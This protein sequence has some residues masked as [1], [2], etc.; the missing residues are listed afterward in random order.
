[1]MQKNLQA[2]DSVPTPDALA[3]ESEDQVLVL[4]EDELERV[5]GGNGRTAGLFMSE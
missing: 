4:L 2:S 3:N 5:A 1:M